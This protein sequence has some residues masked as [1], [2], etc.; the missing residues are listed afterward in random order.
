MFER[1]EN[2]SPNQT[3]SPH[4]EN[5]IC[6]EPLLSPQLRNIFTKICKM[7]HNVSV[8]LLARQTEQGFIEHYKP[9]EAVLKEMR[10]VLIAHDT[11]FTQRCYDCQ[12]HKHKY[13]G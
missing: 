3:E 12:G 10:R 11:Y 5:C 7:E 6:H 13:D 8:T 2:E 9:S 1:P 4:D